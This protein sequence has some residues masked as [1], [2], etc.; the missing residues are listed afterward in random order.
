MF[1]D[2]R[3]AIEARPKNFGPMRGAS[4]H[5]KIKGPCGDTVDV[6]LDIGSN[7]IQRATFMSDGCAY[8]I[9]C[10][11][12]AVKLAEGMRLETAAELTSTQ[13]LEATGPVPEDHQ[14]CALL[15]ANAIKQ[16]LE[17]FQAKSARIPLGQRLKQRFNKK[18]NHA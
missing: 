9:H 8:S 18:R 7:K 13:V 2:V 4:V 10:C 5:A 16:A 11:S 6:W 14:H 17:N 1:D 15:A 3:A 12:V